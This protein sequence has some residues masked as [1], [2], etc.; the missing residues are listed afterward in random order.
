V[1]EIQLSYTL[2]PRDEGDV[3]MPGTAKKAN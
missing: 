3:P 2:F 1:N